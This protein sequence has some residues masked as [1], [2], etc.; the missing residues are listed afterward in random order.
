MLR[1]RITDQ[2]RNS[3]VSKCS[4]R[5]FRRD[6]LN[7]KCRQNQKMYGCDKLFWNGF[8]V[9]LPSTAHLLNV[10]VGKIPSAREQVHVHATETKPYAS[11]HLCIRLVSQTRHAGWHLQHNRN[12]QAWAHSVTFFRWHKSSKRKAKGENILAAKWLNA[13]W[14]Y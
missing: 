10:T 11:S 7:V 13:R 14:K 2:G 12:K 6:R 1:A 8:A 3:S 5:Y 4:R 9:C